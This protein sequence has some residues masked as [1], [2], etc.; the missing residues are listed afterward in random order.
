MQPVMWIADAE[1]SRSVKA[2]VSPRRQSESDLD[3]S[4]SLMKYLQSSVTP[5]TD[6]I[7]QAI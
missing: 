3:D 5:L 1:S 4:K 2:R 7:P 6:R